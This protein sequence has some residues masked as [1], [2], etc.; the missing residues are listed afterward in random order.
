MRIIDTHAH[1]FPPKIEHKATKAIG[2]FYDK[3]E[4]SHNGSPEELLESGKKAG[5]GKFLVFTT[6]T[7]P[8]QV[9][10]I[11][12]FIIAETREHPEFIGAGTMH[13][14]F[15]GYAEELEKLYDNGIR[16]IKL[17]PDFQ[18]FNLDDDRL[19]PFYS[20]MEEKDMF[21]ITHSGDYRYDYSH[22]GRVAR[23]AGAFPKL[24]CIAAHFG[25]WM[26][27][28]LARNTLCLPNIYVDTSSTY[29]FSGITNVIEGLRAF[30]RK[31][32]FFGCDFPMWDHRG[33]LD[34]LFS[35]GLDDGFLEDILFNNFADFYGLS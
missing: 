8:E 13:I 22:P 25:G 20:L 16:G 26:M 18:R 2:D 7:T 17:H 15:A 29:G 30:D 28:E 1:I 3:S 6:A 21:L 4:M 11:N 23:V 24:R 32:I 9:T 34:M 10:S 35:L 33:E 31:H 12:E 27:W 19:F 5:V 14:D